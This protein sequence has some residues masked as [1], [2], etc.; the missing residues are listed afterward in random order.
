M[1]LIGRVVSTKMQKTAVVEVE[2]L[3]T[4]PRYKKR[5]RQRKKL[6]AHNE[7][8]VKIGDVVKIISNRPLSKAKHFIIKEIVE[9]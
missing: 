2:R 5:I 8:G 1:E 4:H 3:V 9:R 7:L 6:Q